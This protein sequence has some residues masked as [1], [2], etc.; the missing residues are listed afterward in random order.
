[1]CPLED[2]PHLCFHEK[3]KNLGFLIT[4]SLSALV[5]MV[6]RTNRG[7]HFLKRTQKPIKTWQRIYP[8]P[9]LSENNPLALAVCKYA[10][11]LRVVL[12]AEGPHICIN[13]CPNSCAESVQAAHLTQLSVP[14]WKLPITL[15]FSDHVSA[16]TANHRGHVLLSP[17]SQHHKN[18]KGLGGTGVK[19]LKNVWPLHICQWDQEQYN[20]DHCVV[21]ALEK[22]WIVEKTRKAGRETGEPS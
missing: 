8:F 1:M 10:A 14:N 21:A 16:V 5:P 2:S 18:H 7:G 4:S 20:K 12:G 11:S 9:T 17:I 3:S 13:C 22:N 6:T 19:R 15:Q